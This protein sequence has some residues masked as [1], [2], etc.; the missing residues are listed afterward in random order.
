MRQ[1]AKQILFV[2]LSVCQSFEQLTPR[3]VAVVVDP[4]QSVRGKVVIDAFR[5][6]AR[7]QSLV[8]VDWFVSDR[9]KTL[10]LRHL[11]CR[12]D[13]APNDHDGSRAPTKHVKHRTS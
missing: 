2:C 10:I 5:K 4:I 9:N 3:A 1:T 13:C 7:F 6:L 12:F 8:V 11:R